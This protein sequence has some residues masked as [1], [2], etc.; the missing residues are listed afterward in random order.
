MVLA[1]PWA[2]VQSNGSGLLLLHFLV[3]PTTNQP[4]CAGFGPPARVYLANGAFLPKLRKAVFARVCVT[5][6]V[7]NSPAGHLLTP[8]RGQV[9]HTKP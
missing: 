4:F 8:L 9:N 3:E 2:Y 1:I 7:A 5:N 6:D